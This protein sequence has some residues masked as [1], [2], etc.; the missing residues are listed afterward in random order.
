MNNYI[1]I[2]VTFVVTYLIRILPILIFRKPITSPFLKSFLHYAPYVTISV[3]TFPA[4][5]YATNS[6]YS[7]IAAL[8]V[9]I[10]FAYKEKSMPLVAVACLITVFVLEIFI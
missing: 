10:Y 1:Y 8:L 2:L 6:I 3:M 5:I 4:I 7:G 9:G